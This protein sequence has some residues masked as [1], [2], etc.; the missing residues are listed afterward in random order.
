M[1]RHRRDRA[2][3]SACVHGGCGLPRLRRRCPPARAPAARPRMRRAAPRAPGLSSGARALVAARPRQQRRGAPGG[4]SRTAP[5][6]RACAMSAPAVS[7]EDAAAAIDFF[8]L[9]ESLKVRRGAVMR[10]GGAREGGVRCRCGAA[11]GTCAVRCRRR[12]AA[13]AHPP[14]LCAAR[15]CSGARRAMRS[16]PPCSAVPPHALTRGPR[17]AAASAAHQAHRL[18]ARGRGRARVHRGPHVPDGA[19]ARRPLPQPLKPSQP[20]P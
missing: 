15:P 19:L 10:R 20:A 6:R 14:C 18:G 11:L 9:C 3:T 13:A 4:A 2:A 16:R 8:T 1:T 12:A 17:A 5:Q 7:R